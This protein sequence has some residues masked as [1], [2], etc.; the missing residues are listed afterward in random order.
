MW[1]FKRSKLFLGNLT[2]WMI[3]SDYFLALEKVSFSFVLFSVFISPKYF[4][5]NHH[6]KLFF[7]SFYLMT[8]D[9]RQNC[10]CVLCVC[11]C[12]CSVVY[13]GTKKGIHSFCQRCSSW[14]LYQRC[15]KALKPVGKKLFLILSEVQDGKRDTTC[16]WEHPGH[17]AITSGLPKSVSIFIACFSDWKDL[18]LLEIDEQC[19]A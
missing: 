19:C 14:S 3:V 10:F 11:V 7:C 2:S 13:N 9:Q 15:S 6:W 8:L 17:S 16:T 1:K 5:Q 12:V 4:S 18:K